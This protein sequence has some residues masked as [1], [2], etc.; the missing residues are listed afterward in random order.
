[1]IA[2]SFDFHLERGYCLKCLVT[3]T[4]HFGHPGCVR[5]PRTWYAHA[6]LLLARERKRCSRIGRLTGAR[7]VH[8]GRWITTFCRIISRNT[9]DPP[10]ISHLY[11]DLRKC[12]RLRRASR[13]SRL[14]KDVLATRLSP[15]Y[16]YLDL[17]VDEDYMPLINL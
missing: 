17:V 2:N 11:R 13:L 6:D 9:I 8:P 7:V 14:P 16:L 15:R 1:M 10:R 3:R 4:L 5:G 12:G